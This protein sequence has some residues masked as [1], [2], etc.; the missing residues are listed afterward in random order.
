MP[1]EF[2]LRF[3]PHGRAHATFGRRQSSGVRSSGAKRA[4]A[5]ARAA[6]ARRGSSSSVPTPA[7]RASGG[8][9]AWARGT[10]T[11]PSL[12]PWCPCSATGGSGVA[13]RSEP[14]VKPSFSQLLPCPCPLSMF[15]VLK[16]QFFFSLLRFAPSLL[17]LSV[18]KK[19]CV[20]ILCS[21][22]DAYL[23]W[24]EPATDFS[25]FWI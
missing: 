12:S 7:G 9:R 8:R 5:C 18:H 13:G 19:R 24:C 1:T 21:Q 4:R 15:A 23:D 3:H 14:G 17:S 11:S 6:A 20:Y 22:T 10:T 2:F 16:S 25:L